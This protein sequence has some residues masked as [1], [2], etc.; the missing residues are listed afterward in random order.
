MPLTYYDNR[1][2]RL[3]RSD[4]ALELDIQ[5]LSYE[6]VERGRELCKLADALG[7]GRVRLLCQGLLDSAHDINAEVYP[8]GAE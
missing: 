1:G 2:R 5:T 7:D 4:E 6:C 3:T 8:E